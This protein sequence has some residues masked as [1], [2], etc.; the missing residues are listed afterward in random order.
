[1]QL[2]CET[3]NRC[4]TSPDYRSTFLYLMRSCSREL[5]SRSLPCYL[6]RSSKQTWFRVHRQSLASN[7]FM[8]AYHFTQQAPASLPL[9]YSLCRTPKQDRSP[10]QANQSSSPPVHSSSAAPLSL[11]SINRSLIFTPP[12]QY[13]FVAFT[14][15]VRGAEFDCNVHLTQRIFRRRT[16]PISALRHCVTGV[17]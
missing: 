6:C 9:P 1:M 4:W 7:C 15:L 14:H 12:L 5:S 2:R 11:N 17:S 16:T 3:S 10:E 8:L 13:L